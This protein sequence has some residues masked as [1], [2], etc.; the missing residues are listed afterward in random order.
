MA[1]FFEDLFGSKKEMSNGVVDDLISR[2]DSAVD[3]LNIKAGNDIFS[4][5]SLIS[6]SVSDLLINN[7]QSNDPFD[8]FKPTEIDSLF[9][10]ISIPAE[11]IQKYQVYDSIYTSVPIIKRIVTVYMDNI[12]QKDTINNKIFNIKEIK[13]DNF[14]GDKEEYLSFIKKFIE[15]FNLE[16]KL[17]NIVFKSI[18]YGDSYI[19]LVNLDKIEDKFPVVMKPNSAAQDKNTLSEYS[20]KVV[21]ESV[22]FESL[23]KSLEFNSYKLDSLDFNK[24]SDLLFEFKDIT[25]LNEVEDTFI[26]ESSSN[27]NSKSKDNMHGILL[28][29]HNPH[30]I[31]PVVTEYNSVLGYVEI[32][33]IEKKN[34]ES[35]NPTLGFL[36]IIKKVSSNSSGTLEQN[37]EKLIK[38]FA[39]EIAKK[40]ILKYN[41]FY[42][43]DN[44]SNNR[45]KLEKDYNQK[46][47]DNL[48]K[49]IFY[50]LKRMLVESK[51]ISLFH[52]K[53]SVRFIPVNN[54]FKFSINSDQNFP[55][56]ESI[57]SNLVY[58]AKLYLLTQLSNVINKLSRSSIIRKWTVDLGSRENDAEFVNRLKQQLRSNK[59][60]ASDLTTN[61]DTTRIL[62]D[63]RDLLTFTKRGQPYV[64]VETLPLGDSGSNI[65]V[66]DLEQ[67]LKEIMSLSGIPGTYLGIDM[68]V[69]LKD[70]LSHVNISF[71]NTISSIQHNISTSLNDL[72][73]RVASE[74]GFKD[75]VSSVAKIHLVPPI[76]LILQLIES[77]ITSVTNINRLFIDIPALKDLDPLYLLKSYVPYIDWEEYMEYSDSRKRELD[78]IKLK[79]Q[80]IQQQTGSQQQNGPPF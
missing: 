73:D 79:Q 58:P 20:N 28:R 32:N 45:L 35:F 19:E 75:R 52:K 47:K 41:I 9:K 51:S 2:I 62:S 8:K 34:N 46:I 4:E 53:L 67:L 60:T 11:R 40:I 42:S 55:F 26:F 36:D 65:R 38:N 30:N 15:F 22:I 43:N 61:K 21:T 56:G 3:N 29:Y 27:N 50:S 10:D 68:N 17:K 5:D 74:L 18:K 14:S 13:A 66:Q 6:R 63:Y 16:E 44:N 69:E 80:V 24:L 70:Q 78:I 54:M 37:Q 23:K 48:D 59:I 71:A 77:A 31:I 39:V 64:N 49:E 76:A 25:T 7:D 1:G 33:E 12:F 57:L 72:M